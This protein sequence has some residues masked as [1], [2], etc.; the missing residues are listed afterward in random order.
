MTRENKLA[1]VVGFG[2][3]LLVGILISDHFSTARNQDTAD[4]RRPSDPLVQNRRND[5]RLI[6][7]R[8]E[9]E[10]NQTAKSNGLRPAPLAMNNSRLPS[11]EDVTVPHDEPAL[12]DHVE[13]VT[14]GPGGVHLIGPNDNNAPRSSNASTQGVVFHNVQ[15]GESLS[16]IAMQYYGDR[17]LAADLAKFNNIANPDTIRVDHRLR[18]PPLSQLR[19]GAAPPQPAGGSNAAP[20]QPEQPARAQTYTVQAGDSLSEISQKLLGTSRRWRD[21]YELNKDV[22]RDPDNVPVG[23][24]LRIPR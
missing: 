14:I 19:P 23:T 18:I 6:D 20:R 9:E 11:L 1:L 4:L 16:S 10:R 15:R 5:P 2:L 21:I 8:S 22:I 24:T 12:P 13:R 3:I 7:L 17:A